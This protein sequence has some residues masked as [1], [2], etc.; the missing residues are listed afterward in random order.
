MVVLSKNPVSSAIFLVLDLFLLAGVFALLEAHFAATIQVLVY[1][2][3]I[4][5]LF[6]FVIMLLNLT[7]PDGKSFS[8]APL[9]LGVIG[10]TILGFGAICVM[11][12]LDNPVATPGQMTPA[13]IEEQGGNTIVLAR[14]LFSRHVWSFELAS[15]IILLAIV[16][17]VMIAKR[18]KPARPVARGNV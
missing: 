5:V 15:L 6:M 11:M 7:P 2:G 3:A 9:E 18:D 13:V 17:S 1:A 10:F 14:L 4:V 12:L 16:G 8:I